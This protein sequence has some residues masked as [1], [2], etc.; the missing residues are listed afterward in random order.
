MIERR[1]EM[2]AMTRSVICGQIFV[3]G[4]QGG[5]LLRAGRS[6]VA[7]KMEKVELSMERTMKEQ[8]K[9]VLRRRILAM[10]TRTLTFY[11]SLLVR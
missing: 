9:F 1:R 11:H 6:L 7:L 4:A 10:R 2:Q 8:A 3:E 5:R